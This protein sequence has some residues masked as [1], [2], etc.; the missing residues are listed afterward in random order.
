MMAGHFSRN[1]VSSGDLNRGRR[2]ESR[3]LFGYFLHNAKSDNSF[4]F[5]EFRGSANLESAHPNNNF[6][7]TKLNPFGTSRGFPNLDS[8]RRNGGFAQTQLK[9]FQM[10]ASR[11]CK[12]RISAPKQKLPTNKIKTFPKGDSRFCK[13]RISTQNY[14]FALTQ[15]NS[16]PLRGN[17]YFLLGTK[18]RTKKRPIRGSTLRVLFRRRFVSLKHGR[19]AHVRSQFSLFRRSPTHKNLPPATFCTS[20]QL[21]SA[22]M[23]PFSVAAATFSPPC[24]GSEAWA[25]PR[26]TGAASRRFSRRQAWLR[27][28]QIAEIPHIKAP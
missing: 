18:S 6:P 7:L 23:P 13:P 1:L 26:L 16:L 19:L 24:G 11:V 2:T 8:A 10:G 5:R 3:V 22:A 27:S 15:L 20:E 17:S 21:L 12:P 9:P 14:N 28:W 25:S 4:P